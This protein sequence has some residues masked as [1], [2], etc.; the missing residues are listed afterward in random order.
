MKGMGRTAP[1][2]GSQERKLKNGDRFRV[3]GFGM[4]GY[5]IG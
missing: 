3:V 2:I 1:A 4:D 5:H